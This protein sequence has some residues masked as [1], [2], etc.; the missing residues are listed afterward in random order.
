[1]AATGHPLL[2][3]PTYGGEGTRFGKTAGPLL[4]G[5]MLHAKELSLI[6]PKTGQAMRFTCDLPKDFAE[7]LDRLRKESDE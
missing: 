7:V 6:H 5:Q 3:D 4:R 1:M 2:G